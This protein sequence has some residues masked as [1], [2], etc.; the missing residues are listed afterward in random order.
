M[1]PIPIW[2]KF[3][4]AREQKR[5]LQEKLSWM[6][7]EEMKL[8][9]EWNGMLVGVDYTKVF[10]S[11]T[12]VGLSHEYKEFLRLSD[13]NGRLGSIYSIKNN[14][15]SIINGTYNLFI[16]YCQLELMT[17]VSL[18]QYNEVIR[19]YE[20]TSTQIALI[21]EQLGKKSIMNLFFT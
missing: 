6:Q 18:Y 15:R 20:D 8:S 17:G 3:L 1:W 14:G 4:K 7:I 19:K 11:N 16:S 12:E 2:N 21:Q 10:T 13:G 9:L 5:I